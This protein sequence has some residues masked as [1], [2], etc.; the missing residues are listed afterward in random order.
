MRVAK[1][2]V[3]G[4]QDD[5]AVGAVGESDTTV[6][7][8]NAAA[9]E[10]RQSQQAPAQRIFW[11]ARE[12]AIVLLRGYITQQCRKTKVGDEHGVV[13]EETGKNAD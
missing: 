2:R 3:A 7:A 13:D 9:L 5:P 8:V 12:V 11:S 6:G 1:V 10:A 4:R